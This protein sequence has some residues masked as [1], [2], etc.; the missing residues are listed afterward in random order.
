LQATGQEDGT[1]WRSY[2]LH[3]EGFTFH[4]TETFPQGLYR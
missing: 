3:G 2:R 1:F 4:I